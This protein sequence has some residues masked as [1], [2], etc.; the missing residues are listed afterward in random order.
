MLK[1]TYRSYTKYVVQTPFDHQPVAIPGRQAVSKVMQELF[2]SKDFSR[3]DEV[4]TL[5]KQLP[6]KCDEAKEALLQSQRASRYYRKRYGRGAESLQRISCILMKMDD[7]EIT[8]WAEGRCVSVRNP[9][10]P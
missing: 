5:L 10:D 9:L 4:R 3:R 7:T 2:P 8:R 1:A 6:Q